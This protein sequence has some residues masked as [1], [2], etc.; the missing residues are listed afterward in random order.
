[1][2]VWKFISGYE[3][4]YQVSSLGRVRS[5]DRSMVLPSGKIRRDP[6]RYIKTTIHPKGYHYV[7]MSRDGFT[8]RFLL[9]RI[10]AQTFIPNPE[11]KPQVN[12]I[13][14]VKSNN[15]VENLEWVT[16]TENI[17]HA[18]SS[19]LIV[20]KRNQYKKM[21]KPVLCVELDIVFESISDATKY[22]KNNVNPK[23]YDSSIV[24]CASG[25]VK[26]A[27]GYTWKYNN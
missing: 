6:G 19:G 18:L 3:G 1:M 17:S 15:N 24:D 8:K 4:M 20:R 16:E 10:V 5:V 12:H 27:Y 23:A 11:C 22:L 7:V 9:H 14:G 13:D 21:M 2:E 25:R 26:T